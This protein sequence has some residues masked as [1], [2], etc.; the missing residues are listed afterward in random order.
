MILIGHCRI[1]QHYRYCLMRGA[2]FKF[3][4]KRV[5]TNEETDQK[6]KHGIF[7]SDMVSVSLRCGWSQSDAGCTAASCSGS[8]I[9]GERNE[10]HPCDVGADQRGRR[11]YCLF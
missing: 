4:E 3:R 6:F 9:E 2:F 10:R 11:I 8:V 1:E 7:D 5:K